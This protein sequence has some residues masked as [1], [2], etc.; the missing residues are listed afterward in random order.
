MALVGSLAAIEVPCPRMVLKNRC[1]TIYCLTL[2]HSGGF[3]EAGHQWIQIIGMRNK[4]YTLAQFFKPMIL[5]NCSVHLWSFPLLL[6]IL[7]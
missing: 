6:P 1:E 2:N 7:N 4:C 5:L 3:G